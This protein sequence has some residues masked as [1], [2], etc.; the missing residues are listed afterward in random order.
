MIA[1]RL[2][3]ST[4]LLAVSLALALPVPLLA[5][6][7]AATEQA[8][9]VWTEVER[10]GFRF[11]IPEGAPV[12]DDFDSPAQRSFAVST[13]G[14]GE[15]GIRLGVRLLMPADLAEMPPPGTP[16]FTAAL[17]GFARM[18]LIQ[19]GETLQL[20]SYLLH[21]YVGTGPRADGL[22]VRGVFYI[23][24]ETDAQGNGLL[25]GSLVVGQ[26]AEAAAAIEA[27]FIGSLA[28]VETAAETAPPETPAV[29]PA[30]VDEALDGEALTLLVDRASLALAEGDVV[31]REQQGETGSTV[32]LIT[33]QGHLLRISAV[34]PGLPVDAQG[35][36]RSF[37]AVEDGLLGDHAVWV[38][39]GAAQRSPADAE[40]LEGE[41]FPAR[42]IAPQFC[43]GGSLPYLL[44]LVADAGQ[45]ASL[46]ALQAGLSLSRPEGA[47]DCPQAIEALSQPQ[48]TAEPVAPEP[49]V[50]AAAD[51][52][53][54]DPATPAPAD[55][56]K[57]P[58]ASAARVPDPAPVSVLPATEAGAWDSALQ[59]GTPE[60]MQAY[61]DAWPRGL[62][63]ADARAWLAA[64]SAPL[65]VVS[66]DDQAW[67]DALSDARPQAL[68][69]YLKA[70]PQGAYV[71]AARSLL[72]N[73][74]MG[75]PAPV[76]APAPAPEP[77]PAGK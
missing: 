5:Q 74:T 59:V 6:D 10:F 12:T 29:E 33:A 35:L 57:D 44:A 76:V 52:V 1:L 15:V 66:G 22:D 17:S 43:V 77:V 55:P 39:R 37:D 61:L 69:S 71:E 2:R 25:V 18:E 34:A 28:A 7:T 58:A 9:L 36:L 21:A 38:V 65:P 68:W 48:T 30:P 42:L 31:I 19:T 26:G 53:A 51:P 56:G 67:I 63:S 75:L 27:Q 45:E 11:A 16:E 3:G 50:V 72:A 70:W 73:P 32:M 40:A 23:S 47:E 41:V 54:A 46:D 49:P 24:H 14:E 20:G 64:Q 13:T 4:A 8:A 62:H 60:A